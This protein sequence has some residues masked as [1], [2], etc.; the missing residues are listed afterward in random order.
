MSESRN[1]FGRK[2]TSVRSKKLEPKVDLT[3]MVSISFLLIVFFIVTI[4][5]SKPNSLNLGMPQKVTCCDCI[6]CGTGSIQTL[7][8]LLGENNKIVSYFGSTDFQKE[9]SK[10]LTFEKNG[11]RKELLN[12]NLAIQKAT[13]DPNRGLIVII[14]P[15]KK[16][17]YGN[18]ISI[19]DE[20]AITD[21]HTYAVINY[22][23]PNE[24][25]MLALN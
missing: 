20:M 21:I 22:Y 7:T 12:K 24:F 3:A 14:K 1:N 5:L 6:V 8:L 2:E 10:V 25:K 4:N 15:S 9:N 23:T 11:I 16:C 18:L 19:L 13:G 17:T